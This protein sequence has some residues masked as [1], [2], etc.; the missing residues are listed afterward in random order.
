MKLTRQSSL[1]LAR[2]LSRVLLARELEKPFQPFRDTPEKPLKRLKTSAL[3]KT[4]L[5]PGA[6]ESARAVAQICNLLYRRLAVGIRV[7]FAGVLELSAP[8]R[9]QTCDTADCKPARRASRFR[10]FASLRS[11]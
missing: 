11:N 5:K 1:S 4:R 9:L 6:N 3:A 8:R 7:V 10:V 2:G